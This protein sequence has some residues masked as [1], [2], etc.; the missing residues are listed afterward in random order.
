[1]RVLRVRSSACAAGRPYA[2]AA[3]RAT[4]KME[5][6][7]GLCKRV[8]PCFG[9]LVGGLARRWTTGHAYHDTRIG[10]EWLE[11][12][13]RMPEKNG[14]QARRLNSCQGKVV[15][16]GGRSS[17]AELSSSKPVTI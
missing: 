2:A 10:E 7:E 15:G 17:F 3:R 8:F 13:A 6:R 16:C 9:R 14:G 5:V 4:A 11:R 12:I 1:M